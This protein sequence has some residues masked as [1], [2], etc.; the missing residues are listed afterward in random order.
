[1]NG[2]LISRPLILACQEYHVQVHSLSGIPRSLLSCC[3]CYTLMLSCCCCYTR[4]CWC[5]LVKFREV[6][7]GLCC[8]N[9]GKFRVLFMK[10]QE[11]M[12][13][14][15]FLR[16]LVILVFNIWSFGVQHTINYLPHTSPPSSVP[17]PA[18]F[19]HT[20]LSS[21]PYTQYIVSV[22]AISHFFVTFHLQ[23]CISTSFNFCAIFLCQVSSTLWR[24]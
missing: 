8:V 13:S 12:P 9:S 7:P 20:S 3:C 19:N 11:V 15:V 24:R 4:S 14:L 21:I 2:P 1:M 17:S 16:V 5:I 22:I 23:N 6:V 18:I 10:F